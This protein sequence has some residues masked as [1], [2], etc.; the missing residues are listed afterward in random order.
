MLASC[1]MMATVLLTPGVSSSQE[2]ISPQTVHR[3]GPDSSHRKPL[4]TF[5]IKL[6]LK[7]FLPK[8][9]GD[10]W[11]LHQNKLSSEEKPA[12]DRGCREP[13][14]LCAGA[15]PCQQSSTEGDRGK[16]SLT[17]QLLQVWPG[18]GLLPSQGLLPQPGLSRDLSGAPVS[19]G[20][21]V[22]LTCS[23]WY[24]P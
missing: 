10:T 1:T 5:S 21:Q 6:G 4:S 17:A 19:P 20:G 8:Q 14:F 24:L 7:Y 9:N 15:A 3:T 12:C 18:G 13:S 16:L 2:Q 11:S 22:W 23:T